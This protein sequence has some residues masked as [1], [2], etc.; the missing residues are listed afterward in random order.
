MAI[1][2]FGMVSQM[3]TESI[4]KNIMQAKKT[5]VDNLYRKRTLT[6]WRKEEY[7]KSYQQISDFRNKI[8]DFKLEKNRNPMKT[9]ISDENILS[10]TASPE[11]GSVNSIIKVIALA[12]SAANSSTARISAA[13]S[14]KFN[15]KTQFETA[16]GLSKL[17]SQTEKFSLTING[18]DI[19]VD[20]S[21]SMVDLVADINT[22]MT[23][24]GVKV[25]ASIDP[26]S[27]KFK[28]AGTTPDTVVL[29]AG[30]SAQGKEFLSKTLKINPESVENSVESSDNIVLNG[31]TIANPLTSLKDM[32]TNAAGETSMAASSFEMDING[33]KFIVD[34][35]RSM[36]EFAAQIN[37]ANIGVKAS[38]DANTDRVFFTTSTSGA[39]A[40]ID[41]TANAVGTAGHDFLKNVLHI[42]PSIAK[43]GTN[44]KYNLNGVDLE[45]A[46][47]NFTVAGVNYS[48][49]NIGEA[50]VTVTSDIDK[51]VEN[52]KKFVDAYNEIMTST[53]KYT[54]EKRYRDANKK[55][56]DPLLDEERKEMSESDIKL[57]DEKARQGM[58][59]GDSILR[60]LVSNNRLIMMG[61]YNKDKYSTMSTL[62]V[63]TGANYL[64][65]GM[66][67]VDED[68]LKAALSEDPQAL[69]KLLMGTKD[70]FGKV[71]TKGILD[72]LY[73]GAK[74]TM[75]ELVTKGGAT[76]GSETSS[77]LG[78]E[79][80]TLN[81]M[82]DNRNTK[83]YKEEQRYYKQFAAM[84]VALQKIQQN[85]SW[86]NSM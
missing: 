32:F 54:T 6:Q 25:T 24:A 47:N 81:K 42:D 37:S 2:N 70:E 77:N 5:S 61:S 12:S 33:R 53:N 73:E 56:L 27:G 48:L 78:K 31:G 11:A 69:D 45:N 85:S 28:L 7:S 46:T 64:D 84:E 57:W 60:S 14:N 22:K 23:A 71:K 82:I 40:K 68:K 63:T 75:D 86:M 51:Q 15:L 79:I 74:V 29:M 43:A 66:L 16:G 49:K 19:E 3:D 38:Y 72:K 83:L 20:P 58:L 17:P 35:N 80:D 76:A 21:K 55:L 65:G 9:S 4:V 62:G 13:G 26:L 8:F 52:F 10:A 67:S 59:Y 1:Q 30:S 36:N 44:A 34:T 41:F 18:E 39:D 50:T